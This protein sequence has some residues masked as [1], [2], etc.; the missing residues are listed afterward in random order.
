VSNPLERLSARFLEGYEEQDTLQVL[1]QVLANLE[2]VNSQSSVFLPSAQI[3]PLTMAVLALEAAEGVRDRVRYRITYGIE[4]F[5][6]LASRVPYPVSFIQ[7]DR[8]SL[9]SAIRQDAIDS[10]GAEYVGPHEA[11][12]VGPHVSWRFV[13]RP[14]Q[15][16]A[17]DIVAVGRIELSE[18][19]AQGWTCLNNPCLSP[20]MELGNA[21]LWS[22]EKE[23]PLNTALVPFEVARADLLTPAAA[24]DELTGENNFGEVGQFRALPD[25][26]DPFL[27]AVI[28]IGLA[29][30]SVLDAG[31]L[32]SGLKDDS[33]S[34]IWQRLIIIPM[35]K[36]AQTPTAYRAKTY[37]C[38]RGSQFPPEGGLCP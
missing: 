15:G 6:D 8:F 35:G 14:M 22:V 19:Q 3:R 18:A 38:Q 29:Q 34:A 25:L 17:S 37:E 13:T 28:E 31:L 1:D 27:E 30:D 26:P 5:P 23:T 21:A 33:I 11:F 12:D 10:I 7:V 32:R 4:P 24:I 16:A 20:V 2:P 9:G 36:N